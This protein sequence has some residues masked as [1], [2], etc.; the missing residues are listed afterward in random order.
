MKFEKLLGKRQLQSVLIFFKFIHASVPSIYCN[1]CVIYTFLQ[2]FEGLFLYLTQFLGS[3]HCLNFDKFRYT[4]SF[5]S[6]EWNCKR[7]RPKFSLKP[8]FHM[9]ATI[10]VIAAM[11]SIGDRGDRKSSISAIVVAAIAGE[12]FPEEEVFRRKSLAVAAIIWEPLSSDRG[13]RK[14]SISAI[15]GQPTSIFGKYMFGRRFE[16]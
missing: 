4:V 7:T 5:I 16:I 3:S 12:W 15:Q 9:I 11:W 14:S 13:D 10:D 2:R 8:G 1:N 6:G